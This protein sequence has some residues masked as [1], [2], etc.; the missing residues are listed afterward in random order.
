MDIISTTIVVSTTTFLKKIAAESTTYEAIPLGPGALAWRNT[1]T[2]AN[3]MIPITANI[4]RSSFT[5]NDSSNRINIPNAR[6]NN[7][8]KIGAKVISRK[9]EFLVQQH[10]KQFWRYTNN[11]KRG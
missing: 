10:P 9:A 1:N 2:I 7:S 6:T 4:L 8:K 3:P 5:E 11:E